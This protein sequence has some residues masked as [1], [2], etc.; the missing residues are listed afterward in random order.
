MIARLRL[1]LAESGEET[2]RGSFRRFSSRVS[3]RDIYR[4]SSCESCITKYLS[5]LLRNSSRLAVARK[6]DERQRRST[7]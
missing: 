2:W 1:F 6:H 5:K 7:V 3:L 4:C